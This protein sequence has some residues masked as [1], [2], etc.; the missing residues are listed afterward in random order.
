[1]QPPEPQPEPSPQRSTVRGGGGEA[2]VWEVNWGAGRAAPLPGVSEGSSGGTPARPSRRAVGVS[3][4]PCGSGLQPSRGTDGLPRG[5]GA[6]LPCVGPGVVTG[7]G[8]C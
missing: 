3:P 6:V 7:G 1:M 8:S 5:A 2:R 4:S